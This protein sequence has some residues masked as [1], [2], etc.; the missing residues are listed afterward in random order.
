M[1]RWV[2]RSLKRTCKCSDAHESFLSYCGLRKPWTVYDTYQLVSF[3]LLGIQGVV[4]HFFLALYLLPWIVPSLSPLPG[5]ALYL[6][7]VFMILPSFPCHAKSQYPG[8][9]VCL[10]SQVLQD[11][12]SINRS[13][14]SVGMFFRCYAG[15]F[16]VQ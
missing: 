14:E 7:K 4:Q 9:A 6:Q 8:I 10:E 13:V 5:V 2:Y 11:V 3:P 16:A 1:Q 12:P 15:S